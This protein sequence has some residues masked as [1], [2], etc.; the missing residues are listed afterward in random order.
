MRMVHYGVSLN[1]CL[2]WRRRS[3][4]VHDVAWVGEAVHESRC[5]GAALNQERWPEFGAPTIEAPVQE[6]GLAWW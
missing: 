5:A 1:G 6:Y 2:R 4:A 3:R